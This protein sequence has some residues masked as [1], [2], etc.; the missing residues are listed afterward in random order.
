MSLAEREVN[1]SSTQS[2]HKTKTGEDLSFSSNISLGKSPEPSQGSLQVKAK[3]FYDCR[4]EKFPG[5]QE[6]NNLPLILLSINK[7][8]NQE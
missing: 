7:Q 2:V 5:N 8:R 6:S 1:P 3:I 4:E